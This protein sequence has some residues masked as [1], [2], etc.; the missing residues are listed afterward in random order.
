MKTRGGTVNQPLEG[1]RVLDLSW[2]GPGPYCALILAQLG[3]DVIVVDDGSPRG[4]AARAPGAVGA[5]ME[6]IGR[7][8]RRECRRIALDL[9]HPDGQRVTQQLVARADV[10]IEG[11]RPGVAARLGLGAEELTGR[12]PRLV[13]CSISGFGQ[14]GPYRAAAGHDINYLALAG[15]LGL[16]GAS[17]GAPVVP[18]TI[19]ADLAA[20]GLPA[21]VAILAALLARERSGT[22]C[23][24]D[25]A[26]QEGSVALLAPILALRAAGEP[27]RPAGTILTGAAPWYGV[28][29]TADGRFVAVGTIE[30]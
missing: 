16:T 17:D 2:Q 12:Y 6:R 7:Y 29:E 13:Y 1:Y 9:K 14:N 21:A 30:P 5:Y 4:R 19:V 25:A 20:G 27:M 15:L 28:Y 18:G 10:L 24:I 22:G 8:A 11:F 3:A 23:V 26:M